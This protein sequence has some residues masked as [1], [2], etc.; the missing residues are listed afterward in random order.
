MSALLQSG[1]GERQ[2]KGWALARLS[3]GP[4]PPA[5]ALD[6]P[7]HAGKIRRNTVPTEF[8]WL[9]ELF[10]PGGLTFSRPVE[11]RRKMP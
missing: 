1:K 4:G 10:P 2:V 7:A 9:A 5:M 3:F 6:D 8:A 11:K